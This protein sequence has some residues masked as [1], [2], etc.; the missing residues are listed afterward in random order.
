MTEQITVLW[1]YP[2]I[3][4]LHGDRGNLMALERIGRLTGLPVELQRVDK[5]TDPLPLEQ[6]DLLV[7]TSGEVK[8]MEQ[9]AA[10]LSSGD[11]GAA[12]RAFLDRGGFIFATGTSGAVL[13]QET[14]RLDGSSFAGLGLLP[15]RCR[16]REQVYGDDIWF[17]L[18]ED[19]Q[20]QLM[21]NQIQVLDSELLDGGQAFGQIIY[22][23]G[24]HGADD[25]GCREGRIIFT[26]ALG[27]LLVKNPR[28][29][30]RLLNEIAAAKGLAP[31]R[32]L[33]AEDTEYEDRS[34][35][36]IEEFIRRKMA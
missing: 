7:L 10:A 18:N 30:E 34:Y 22:G 23:R 28:Y 6:A 24:N 21:G 17:S 27:P 16:E 13:A 31:S 3:L 9:I 35:Q 33:S 26:N 19:P 25:E 32:C 29:T 15:L 2:D 11:H 20:L 14:E 36:L 5:L 8:S 1:L 12:L 4:N